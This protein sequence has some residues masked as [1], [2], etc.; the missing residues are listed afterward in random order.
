MR[1]EACVFNQAVVITHTG[2]CILGSAVAITHAGHCIL[3]PA[4]AISHM[5]AQPGHCILDSA[6]AM[7]RCGPCILNPAVGIT[8]TR[9]CI[10]GSAL[11]IT[12]SGPWVPVLVYR[13]NLHD[14][15]T[16]IDGKFQSA[17]TGIS[18]AFCNAAGHCVMGS[19]CWTLQ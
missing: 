19:A 14:L 2:H 16:E 5:H 18:H 15:G 17:F 6:V 8:P 12:R 11:A 3:D 13:E 9:H 4:V 10:L 1:C 7:T